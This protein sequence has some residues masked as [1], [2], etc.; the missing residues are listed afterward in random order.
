MAIRNTYY[1]L[2]S[3]LFAPWINADNI[4]NTRVDNSDQYL[5]TFE[6]YYIKL[7]LDSDVISI[8]TIKRN[9]NIYEVLTALKK[10]RKML[11]AIYDI[12]SNPSYVTLKANVNNYFFKYNDLTKVSYDN[13][14]YCIMAGMIFDVDSNE[15]LACVCGE[16][17]KRLLMD[18]VNNPERISTDKF[19]DTYY[20]NL[21]NNMRTVIKINKSVLRTDNKMNKFLKSTFMNM[22]KDDASVN[23]IK[24]C[25]IEPVRTC[26]SNK[27]DNINF[28]ESINSFLKLHKALI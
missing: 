5:G 17:D 2:T 9:V 3:S 1:T 10:N 6:P 11:V 15:V 8:P 25:S 19:K 26:L 20:H 12:G 7:D 22:L 18:I 24:F 14:N 23:E 4:F 27:P 13:H 21:K 28:S 16:F